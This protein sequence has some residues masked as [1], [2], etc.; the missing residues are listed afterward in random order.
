MQ[1]LIESGI[2]PCGLVW[3]VI[4]HVL[5]W[6]TVNLDS[7]LYISFT[8]TCRTAGDLYPNRSNCPA[9]LLISASTSRAWSESLQ[10][11]RPASPVSGP[12][13]VSEGFVNDF[14]TLSNEV[15]HGI[16]H[17]DVVDLGIECP[18]YSVSPVKLVQIEPPPGAEDQNSANYRV[19]EGTVT[20]SPKDG[21]T[22]PPP[23][24]TVFKIEGLIDKNMETFSC[25]YG[26]DH[27]LD[28]FITWDASNGSLKLVVKMPE[29]RNDK[30]SVEGICTEMQAWD[31]DPL[32]STFLQTVWDKY[33]KA[34]VC[35]GVSQGD[36]EVPE[37]LSELL[38]KQIQAVA[39][40]KPVDWHPGSNDCVRDLVHP[41]MYPFV[42]GKSPLSAHGQEVLQK[43]ET[44]VATMQG[45]DAVDQYG[46]A[47]PEGESAPD[48]WGRC[49]EASKYQ[50]LPTIFRTATSGDVTI[51]GYINNLDKSK[52]PG[53]YDTLARLFEI[54]LPRFEKVY[55]YLKAVKLPDENADGG[56]GL[57]DVDRVYDPDFESSM[58][59]DMELR[60]ITKIVDYELQ[61][62][63]DSID[64]VFHVEGMSTDH[65]IMT[66]IYIVDR[67][68]DFTGGTLEFRRSFLDFEGS[69]IFMDINQVRHLRAESLVEDCIRPL[70]SLKTPKGRVIVFPNSHIHR[71]SKMTRGLSK[72]GEA[73]NKTVSRRRVVVFWVV[74]PE[75]DVLT[76]AEVP[77][78]QGSMPESV[79]KQH[80][81]SLMEERKKHKGK[82]NRDRKISLCEH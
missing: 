22:A 78:Q 2:G 72:K 52:Y 15:E 9:I 60:V 19:F 28:E 3:Q 18:G 7:Q 49:F 31:T 71:L 56:E 39:D 76:T 48:R 68:A 55:A 66:G 8:S 77:I 74:D 58:L 82:L 62:D 17:G 13:K 64:G 69:H 63:A 61:S 21:T 33:Q 57:M 25:Q 11:V 27:P 12:E 29:Y 51:E 36:H 32:E 59:R 47:W 20:L 44:Y 14:L 37:Q 40:T 53:L 79:A 43:I 73:G 38:N 80:R 46:R 81:L 45:K 16:A 42:R 1:P 6:L 41:S 34:P 30:E 4:W 50:W 5:H 65:I 54:F 10:M 26:I 35:E 70:G 24:G 75:R 67:D 23:V